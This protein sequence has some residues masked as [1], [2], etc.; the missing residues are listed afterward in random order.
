MGGASGAQPEPNQSTGNNNQ[1][2]HARHVHSTHAHLANESIG[3]C[4][5]LPKDSK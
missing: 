3:K 2:H 5:R 1:L 4:R